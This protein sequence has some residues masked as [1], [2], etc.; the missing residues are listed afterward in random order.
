[1]QQTNKMPQSFPEILA[2]C[3]F[4]ECWACPGMSDK[5]QQI[6]HDLTKAFTWISNY[7][8]NM[9]IISQTVSKI[10]KIKKS[11]HLIGGEHFGLYLDMQFSQNHIANV[12]LVKMPT[13]SLLVQ[14]CLAYPII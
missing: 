12:A 9:K 14:I 1:M 2:L 3:Y 11:C 6:L 5:T 13:I 7:I 10:L 4:G 8:Q